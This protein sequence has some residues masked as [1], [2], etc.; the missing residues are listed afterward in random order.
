[1]VPLG[2]LAFVVA[3]GTLGYHALG[4]GRWSYGDCAYMTIITLTTVGYSEVIDVE[5]VEYARAFT[6][7]L[8]VLG[9]GTVLTFASTVTAVFV[10]GDLQ[11][12]YR[13]TRMRNRIKKLENHYVVCGVGSTGR[14]VIEELI[15]AG[16]D[17]VAI[18]LDREHLEH[19]EAEHPE[20]FAYVIGDATDD[21][22]LE[23]ASM[24]T[25][26]G[27]VAALASD[28]D[29]LYLVVSARQ[30][31][32]R[33]RIVAR[34]SDLRVLDK[35][36]KAGADTVVSPNYIGGMRMVSELLRPH[37]VQFLDEML[38]D[39][40]SEMRI[41]E[42][43]LPAGSPFAGKSLGEVDIRNEHDVGVLAV[44]DPASGAYHYN[45]GSEFRLGERMTLV[46]LGSIKSVNQ[47]RQRA[48]GR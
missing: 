39:R 43:S 2:A 10:E 42:V 36:R 48:E 3:T 14:H 41:E 18:D 31:N 24:A 28:K 30:A 19:I 25:A 38:R 34:G 45:P 1:M 33:A 7:L 13:K 17:V 20:H 35:L 23:A 15:L 27:I 44:R 22:T 6:M 29:N 21:E 40:K 11:R 37:V 4:E 46:V 32:P 9:M 5:N 47:L 16:R 12:A 26:T 8:I